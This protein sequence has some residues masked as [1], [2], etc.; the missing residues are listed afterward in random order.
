M[1]RYPIP[2]ID[3]PEIPA[4][5]ESSHLGS[6]STLGTNLPPVSLPPCLSMRTGSTWALSAPSSEAS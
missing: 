5:L 4:T 6:P 2:R 3:N 1:S